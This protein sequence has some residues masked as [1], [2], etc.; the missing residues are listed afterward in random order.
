MSLVQIS[1]GT[2]AIPNDTIRDFHQFLHANAE[3]LPI[4]GHNHFLPSALQFT[5]HLPFY[6]Y[7][8]ATDNVLLE[9][10]LV[11]QLVKNFKNFLHFIVPEI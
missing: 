3:I 10:L 1:A 4:L 8:L 2:P 11:A 5:I 6:H 7:S 9:K